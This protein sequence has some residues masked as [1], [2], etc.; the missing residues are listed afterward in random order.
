MPVAYSAVR[1]GRTGPVL[2]AG[3]DHVLTSATPGESE[4]FDPSSVASLWDLRL[5]HLQRRACQLAARELTR[6]EWTRHLGDLPYRA[7]C[8]ELAS[9]P[10]SP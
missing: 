1:L 2:A 4:V 5:V 9:P 7:L 8:S 6:D 10:S 3:R